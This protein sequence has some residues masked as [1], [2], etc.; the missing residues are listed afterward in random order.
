MI[1]EVLVI[2]SEATAVFETLCDELPYSCDIVNNIMILDEGTRL[3]FFDVPS[4]NTSAAYFIG[5]L[6]CTEV[7]YESEYYPLEMV[8][9]MTSR[10][11]SQEVP[12]NLEYIREVL[13]SEGYNSARH[14][15]ETFQK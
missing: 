8:L 6:C 2:G 5:G 1:N 9:Y 7:F 12:Q 13:R 10:I 3:R 4:R 11:R 15:Y 14:F